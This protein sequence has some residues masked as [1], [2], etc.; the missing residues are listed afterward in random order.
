M[1]AKVVIILLCRYKRSV[2]NLKSY[3]NNFVDNRFYGVVCDTFL[4]HKFVF[5]LNLRHMLGSLMKK[6]LSEDKMASVFAKS[7]LDVI[8]KGFDDVIGLV[9]D[10]PVFVEIPNIESNDIKHFLLI[11][12]TA[13]MSMMDKHFLPE[14]SCRIEDEVY[15]AF[16]NELGCE[17]LTLRK[18]VSEYDQDMMRLN[19]PSKNMLYAMSKAFFAKY[20]LNQYQDQYFKRMQAPNP[21]FLKRMDEIMMNF[22]WDWEA[23]FKKF[24]L[25]A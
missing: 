23:F 17:E 25:R 10:D 3:V 11:V 8:D 14:Q 1:T 5:N 2:N 18:I 24:K 12:I 9:Q 19:H 16:A 21:L 13:N 15:T 20:E 22:V 7:M 6:K 4:S